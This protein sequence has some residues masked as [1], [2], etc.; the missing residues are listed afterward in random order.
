M[1][2]VDMFDWRLSDHF[3][4]EHVV[5]TEKFGKSGHSVSARDARLCLFI[6]AEA[7]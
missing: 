3:T 6:R 4:K 2:V 7:L 1:V 5:G